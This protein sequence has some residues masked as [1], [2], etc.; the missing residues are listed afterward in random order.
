MG[1]VLPDSILSNPGLEWIREWLLDR[2]QVIASVDLP[3]ET[4]EP[5]TGTQ[6]SVLILRKKDPEKSYDED[7]EIFMSTP[8][9]VGHDRRGNPVFLKDDE[10]KV[11]VNEKG[12][13]IQDDDLPE[14]TKAFQEW[15][16]EKGMK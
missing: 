10:G 12:I 6:T 11:K 2:V 7:Y 8:D 16:E 1:L 13:P 15:V 14:V 5:H 3:V 9:K 4:F